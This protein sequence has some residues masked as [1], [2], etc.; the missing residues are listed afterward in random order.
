MGNRL[1]LLGGTPTIADLL[2]VYPSIGAEEEAAAIETIRSGTLSGFFGSW[3][4]G[5]KLPSFFA[6]ASPL[7]GNPGLVPEKSNGWDVGLEPVSFLHEDPDIGQVDSWN[8]IARRDGWHA[9][10]AETIPVR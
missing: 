5:F 9:D 4:E 1:A 2:P 3:G 6:L 10:S 7:V 8:V